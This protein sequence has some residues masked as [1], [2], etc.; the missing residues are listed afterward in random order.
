METEQIKSAKKF[1]LEYKINSLIQVILLRY[2]S[3]TILSTICFAIVGV[4]LSIRPE[5]FTNYY[6]AYTSCFVLVSI[7]LVSFGRFL[8]LCRKDANATA[9]SIKELPDVDWSKPL[10]EKDFK[11]DNWPETL[12]GLLVLTIIMAIIS[13]LKF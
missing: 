12:F 13:M 8:Y 6:L 2:Q 3:L 5:L 10:P 4:L 9:L 1:A 11:I 7:A